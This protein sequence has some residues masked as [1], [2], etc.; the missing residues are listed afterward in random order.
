[1]F[2]LSSGRITSLAKTAAPNIPKIQQSWKGLLACNTNILVNGLWGVF[3]NT[4]LHR[5]TILVTLQYNFTICRSWNCYKYILC[6]KVWTCITFGTR[7]QKSP[8]S[9]ALYIV[10][11]HC[12]CQ[13]TVLQG[14]WLIT[15]M[16]YL[17]WTFTHIGTQK[18]EVTEL[19]SQIGHHIYTLLFHWQMY[20]LV[21]YLYIY[22]PM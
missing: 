10:W 5:Y 14:M 21:P 3:G 8:C 19:Y 16:W 1:M 7:C 18:N 6:R 2:S 13:C 15:V 12:H 20:H 9:H 4:P 17:T 22:V 11:C